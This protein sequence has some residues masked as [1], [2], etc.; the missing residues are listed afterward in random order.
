MTLNDIDENARWV[1]VGGGLKV[2]DLTFTLQSRVSRYAWKREWMSP[3]ISGGKH[4]RLLR[5]G[6]VGTET[7]LRWNN[8]VPDHKQFVFTCFS[9]EHSCSK[10]KISVWV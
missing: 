10:K 6:E 4:Q 1:E 8:I 3:R 2:T 9:L 7:L 5:A